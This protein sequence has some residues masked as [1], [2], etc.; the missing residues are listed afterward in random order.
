MKIKYIPTYSELFTYPMDKLK[1]VKTSGKEYVVP[2]N[3]RLNDKIEEDDYDNVGNMFGSAD[4]VG[5]DNIAFE[6]GVL[7][8]VYNNMDSTYFK[9]DYMMA[10]K[11][12]ENDYFEI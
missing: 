6:D 11:I 2:I 8:F 12:T 3:I 9:N 1:V 5:K 10:A 4:S 7:Y